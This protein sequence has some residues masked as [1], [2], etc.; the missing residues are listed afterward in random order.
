[1]EIGRYVRNAG[2]GEP[3]NPTAVLLG[4]FASCSRMSGEAAGIRW[5]C[6]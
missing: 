4:D 1:M 3:E 6:L 5:I 2:W